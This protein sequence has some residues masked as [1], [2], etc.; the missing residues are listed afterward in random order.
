MTNLTQDIELINYFK[1]FLTLCSGICYKL[2]D[3][4]IFK[5][6]DEITVSNLCIELKNHISIVNKKILSLF[7]KTQDSLLKES[8]INICLNVC[9]HLRLKMESFGYNYINI[10]LYIE[11]IL[12]KFKKS[13]NTKY[14]IIK[15]YDDII[16][17]INNHDFNEIMQTNSINSCIRYLLK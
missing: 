16:Y 10:I 3:D 6:E 17:K 1:G 8:D 9:E 12:R 11:C 7:E 14:I 4:F 5:N 15:K 13:D 2:I